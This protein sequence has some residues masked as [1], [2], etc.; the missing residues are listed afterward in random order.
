MTT[1]E[2]YK[3]ALEVHRRYRGKIQVVSKVL[4]GNTGTLPYTIHLE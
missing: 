1:E 4:L 3:K 2:L